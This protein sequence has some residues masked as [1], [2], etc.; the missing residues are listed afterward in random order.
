MALLILTIFLDVHTP[1]TPLLAGL[2]AIDWLGA[3]TMASATIMFLLGL[4]LGG[5][6][7]PWSSPTV[8]CLLIFGII[9]FALFFTAQFKLSPDPI[10]PF[11]I[12][13]HHSNLSAL[14]VCF[15]DAMVFN[16]VA[17]FVPLYFQT[18]LAKSPL[19]SGVMMLAL[20]IPLSIFSASAGWIMEKTGRYL[21][22]LRGGMFLMTIGVGLFI[23]FQPFASWP[24]IILFLIIVG[25]GFGPNFHAPLI[26]LQSRLQPHDVAAGTATFGFVRMLSGAIGLVLGQV[27]FQGRMQ[28]QSRS[29][30]QTGIPGDIVAS[31]GRGSAI[32]STTGYSGLTVAQDYAIRQT[33]TEAF[34]H[35]WILYTVMSFL[36]LLASFGI[37]RQVLTTTHEEVKTGIQSLHSA[38][39]SDSDEKEKESPQLK[40]IGAAV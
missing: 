9:T 4:Q 35:M 18:V 12:F 7:L 39:E 14:A 33:K 34:S 11:R 6:V 36:G 24:R 1:H 19:S 27:I 3:I 20:A 2:K 5:V 30:L 13:S 38:H 17:Y 16:S 10:M 8:V 29:L 28:T 40:Q 23:D 22:L 31:L 25:I 37:T 32:S 21:E 26:A 15:F